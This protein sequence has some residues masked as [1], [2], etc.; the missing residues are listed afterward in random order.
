MFLLV[1]WIAKLAGFLIRLI[2]PKRGTDFPGKLARRLYRNFPARFKNIDFGKV[3]MVTGSNGKTTSTNLIFHTLQKN[4]LRAASNLKGSNMLNGVTTVFVKASTITGKLKVD[5]FVIEVDERSFP[6]VYGNFPAGH[7]LVTNVMQDQIHRNGEP[8]FIYQ[9]LK[10]TMNENM[11]LYMNND[12]P[13]S[14]SYEDKTK[15]RVYFGVAKTPEAKDE[16]GSLDITM[17]CPKCHNK[18]EF[19]F[20][21]AAN[22]GAFRCTGCGFA[23]EKDPVLAEDADFEKGRFTIGGVDFPM[24]YRAPVM[25]YNYAAAC[26]IAGGLGLS[27][28]Q[29]ADAFG[30]FVNTSGRVETL[31]YGTKSLKYIRMKQENPETLQGALDAIAQDKSPK[32]FMIGLCTLDER[33]PQ[34]VP[35]YA[36]T[37]YAYDCDFKPL[38]ASGVEKIICFSEYVCYDV[39][40]RLIYDG[41]NREDMITVNSDKPED[42]LPAL[43]GI[44]NDN[45]YFITLMRLMEGFQ[46]Y[47]KEG[48]K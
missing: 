11:T 23:S 5:Y 2:A 17:P 9:V 46:K 12:E 20:M 29:A 40:C 39:A 13:R 22:M 25:L 19:D 10:E 14:K 31:Q 26:A 3:V 41:A 30:S 44:D 8:D 1:L 35:H 24:P 37:Y 48:A 6:E 16:W 42:V 27:L 21:N 28:E 43:D 7:V 45:V 18:I 15:K 33:R 32:I 47:I 34:W 36:N 4:G 38:L